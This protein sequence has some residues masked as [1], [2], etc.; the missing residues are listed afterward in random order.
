MIEKRS[1]PF[2]N[3]PTAHVFAH[4][5]VF[6]PQTATAHKTAHVLNK[7][8]AHVFDHCRIQKSRRCQQS[9]STAEPAPAFCQRDKVVYATVIRLTG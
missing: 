2:P 5:N 6:F 3:R 8:T 4:K 9:E 1:S 7:S